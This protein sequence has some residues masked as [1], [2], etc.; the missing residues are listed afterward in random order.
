MP[1]AFA[2]DAGC[3]TN[4]PTLAP[5]RSEHDEGRLTIS[6][7]VR[8]LGA[9]GAEEAEQHDADL[10]TVPAACRRVRLA[11]GSLADAAVG[12]DSQER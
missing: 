7:T 3:Q 9:C 6:S 8:W 12:E 10:G 1:F 4:D 2:A 11:R 5:T